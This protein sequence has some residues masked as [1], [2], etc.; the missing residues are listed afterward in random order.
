M[1]LNEKQ[2]IEI[3]KEIKKPNRRSDQ[4]IANEYQVT[5]KT[6][7]NIRRNNTWK[8]LDRNSIS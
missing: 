5:R 2:V 3:I 1:A 4:K 6:I 7:A 8:Y